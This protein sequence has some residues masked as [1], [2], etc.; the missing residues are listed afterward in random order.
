M[1]QE[2]LAEKVQENHADRA[3][4]DFV[5]WNKGTWKKSGPT[6]WKSRRVF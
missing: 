1:D 4:A 2:M 6:P 5:E 3:W